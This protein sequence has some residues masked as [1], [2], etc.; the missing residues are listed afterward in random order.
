MKEVGEA[1]GNGSTL[2]VCYLVASVA[3]CSRPT[4]LPNCIMLYLSISRARAEK[5]G[6]S[7]GVQDYY[8]WALPTHGAFSSPAFR[9]VAPHLLTQES[10]TRPPILVG[11]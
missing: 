3:Y 4:P 10:I 8:Q 7:V 2:K 5:K 6:K 1:A 11:I 9:V